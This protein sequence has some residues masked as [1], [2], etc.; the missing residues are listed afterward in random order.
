MAGIDEIAARI[1]KRLSA[2]DSIDTVLL[3]CI[4]SVCSSCEVPYGEA[5]TRYT[6]GPSLYMKA[7]WYLPELDLADFVSASRKLA[8]APGVGLPGRTWQSR[9]QEVIADL[10][11]APDFTRHAMAEAAGL[12]AAIGSP[13]FRGDDVVAVLVFMTSKIQRP[14]PELVQK[15]AALAN[16]TIAARWPL[17]RTGTDHK[18]AR[19]C[20]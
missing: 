8:F 13:V 9:Q 14:L 19:L 11:T 16:D 3:S 17:P 5:W 7:A 4:Q 1:R 10:R 12:R 6:E 15:A 2:A 20:S 18:P